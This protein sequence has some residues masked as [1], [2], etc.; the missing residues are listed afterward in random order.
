MI[1]VLEG[2][3]SERIHTAINNP[4]SAGQQRRYLMSLSAREVIHV[5][6]AGPEGVIGYQTLDLWAPSPRVDRI[7]SWTI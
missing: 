6:E 3:A 1:A 4:W 7:E 2:I 5:A